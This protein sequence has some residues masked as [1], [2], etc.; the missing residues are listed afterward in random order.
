LYRLAE[1]EKPPVKGNFAQVSYK[2]MVKWIEAYLAQ[3]SGL[4]GFEANYLLAVRGFLSEVEMPN[5]TREEIEALSL[6]A[7]ATKKLSHIIT[8]FE[9]SVE[10]SSGNY[11]L[12]HRMIE[13][14]PIYFGF[15]YGTNWYYHAPLLGNSCEAIVYVRDIQEDAKQALSFN[16]KLKS[17]KD[18]LVDFAAATDSFVDYY[19]RKSKNECRLVI[20]KPMD[21]FADGDLNTIA[22]WIGQ[23]LQTLENELI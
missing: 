17:A 14:Y 1:A 3:G 13:S 7:E 16:A 6:A 12:G 15:R 10:A 22:E 2:V 21:G 8:G 19:E 11:L 5:I 18:Q 20:R 23:A 9:K 4:S